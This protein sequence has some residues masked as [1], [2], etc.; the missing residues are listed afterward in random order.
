MT[1]R[2]GHLQCPFCGGYE[3]DR[4]YVASSRVDSCAC[5]SC[6]ARWEEDAATGAYRGR[7]PLESGI[8]SR[9]D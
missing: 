2:Q 9:R 3:V 6:S 4:L 8:S 5:L 1:D 7:S